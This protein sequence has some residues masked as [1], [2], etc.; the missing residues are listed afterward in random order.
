MRYDEP[1]LV[2]GRPPGKFLK[3]QPSRKDGLV[4]V[5]SGEFS[6]FFQ[7][8]DFINLYK[9]GLFPVK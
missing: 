9:K 3:S 7:S 6:F 8:K 2:L 5:E 4:V 1:R